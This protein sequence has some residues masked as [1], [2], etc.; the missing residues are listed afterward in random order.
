MNEMVRQ[1]WGNTAG[2]TAYSQYFDAV[3][4]MHLNNYLL[5]LENTPNWPNSSQIEGSYRNSVEFYGLPASTAFDG[6]FTQSVG[7]ITS[8]DYDWPH[9]L[10]MDEARI[11]PSDVFDDIGF[12]EASQTLAETVYDTIVEFVEQGWGMLEDIV[13]FATDAVLDFLDEAKKTALEKLKD[14]V[15][16]VKDT[17]EDVYDAIKDL[18][19][20][21]K[22][23]I[24]R[25]DPLVLDLDGDGIETV[26]AT[27][28][29]LFDHDGDGVRSGTGWIS[30]DDGIL[31]LDRN[32]NGLIDS[33]RELFGADTVLSDGSTAT[34]GFAALADLDANDDGVFDAQDGQYNNVRV[35]RD[36]NQ[37]G[38]SQ[39]NE[40]FTLN[41]LGVASIQLTPSTTVDLDLGNGNVVDN[42]GTYTRLDGTVGLAGD[43]LLAM[44]H[45]FRDFT[46]SLDPVE[47]EAEARLLPRLRGS[48]AVR[49]LVEAAS[50]SSNLLSTL[51]GFAPGTTRDEMRGELDLVISLWAATSTM[52][53]SE[54]VLESSG[55]VPRTVLF[56]GDVPASVVAQGQA[57]VEAWKQQQHAHLAPII[58]I[59][60]RFN[61][62]SLITYQ[63][64]RV[65][66]GGNTYT[67]TTVALPGG[68]TEQVMSI[69]LRDEQIAALTSSYAELLESVYARLVLGTRLSAYIESIDTE[70]VGD[71]LHIGLASFHALLE[72][73][74]Q[75]NLAEALKD[76]VDLYRYGGSILARADWDGQGLLR[77]WIT[78]ASATQ[79]GLAALAAAGITLAQFGQSGTTG[80][81]V[82]WGSEDG[83]NLWGGAGG[84]LLVGNDGGD[85]LYGQDGRDILSGGAGYDWLN[86]G[87][88]DDQLTGGTENDSL[89]GGE[90]SD[91]Y[92]YYLGDDSDTINN[93][94]RSAGRFDVLVLG[95]GIT[96]SGVTVRRLG[97]SLIINVTGNSDQITVS[98][99]FAADGTG[100]YQ[101]DQIRFADGTVW[102]V[103]TLKPMVVIPTL[104]DDNLY[105]YAT[106]DALM[107]LAGN[108]NLFGYGGNDVL[109][110]GTGN[111]T[112]SGGEGSDTYIFNLGD[113]RDVIDGYDGSAGSFDVLQLGVGIAPEDVQA[114]RRGNSL[115]LMLANG[116]DQVMVNNYFLRDGAG[117]FQV[118]EIR[119]A[120]GTLWDV[121]EVKLRVQ[122]A[123]QGSD[124]LHGYET[125]D[126][127]G[128][129][130]GDDILNG[131]GGNDV[132]EGGLGNDTLT[133]G[134]GSDVYH[135][136][137][138]DGQDVIDNHDI[139]AGRVDALQLGAGIVPADVTARRQGD[140]L[141]LTFAN[142]TDRIT[143]MNYFAGDAAAGYQLDEIRFANGVVWNVATVMPLVQVPT[144]GAD[145]I[146]GYAGSDALVGLGGNDLIQGNAGDDTLEGG[147]GNDALAGGSGSDVYIFNAGD[148][149]D[150]I[151]NYDTGAGRTDSLRFGPGILPANMLVR[152][153]G[154]SLVL[155]FAGSEDQVTISNYF[156][157]DADGA[158]RLDEIR[159]DD[160]T[161]WDVAAVRQM[162]LAPTSGND[163]IQGYATND[164]IMGGE[165]NDTLHGYGGNDLLQGDEGDDTL[166]AGAGHDV[167]EGGGGADSLRGDGGDDVL[168]GGLGNDFLEGGAG[169]DTY[170]FNA[171]DG[172][173]TISNY[174]GDDSRVDVLA[175]GVGINPENVVARRVENN[176]VL[177]FL[178]SDD[179]VTVSNFFL[180]DAAGGYQLDQIRFLDANQTVWDVE[181]MK[182]LVL[183]P[184][185]GADTLRG[186]STNDSLS[187][188]DGDDSLF[189]HGG[190]DV[191]NG[192]AGNDVLWGGEDND[193]LFGGLGLD[194]LNGDDGDDVLHGGADN[195]TLRGGNGSDHLTGGT[196]NDQLEGGQ[197]DDH[198]YF[199]TGDGQDIIADAQG[200]STIHLS[201]IPRQQVYLRRDGTTL[202]LSFLGSST[203]G[204]R[205]VGFFDQATQLALRGLV[206]DTGDGVP[207][208]LDAEGIDAAAL[209][210]T[211]LD[212][213][214]EGNSLGNVI[215]GLSGNDTV[216]GGA[217]NDSMDGGAGN[218]LL[219]GQ[220]GNDTLAGAEG[221]DVLNGGAGADHL[222]GGSGNDV[223]V[224]DNAGDVVV[225]SV[226][227]GVDTI[228]SSVSF[229]LIDNVEHLTLIGDADIS[230]NGNTLDNTL[231]G[232]GGNNNLR[233]HSGN[234]VL[235]GREGN[236]TLHGDAGEDHLDGGAG[237]D[238]LVGGT[239]NDVYR[240]D[241]I[242]D[243]IVEYASEGADSVESTAYSYTLSA[244]IESLTLVEASGAY[245]GIGN[246]EVNVL[247]G[248][249]NDNRL[250]GGAGADTMI[251]GYGNDIYVI[252]STGDVIIENADGGTDTV[253]SSISYT[254]GATLENLTLLGS[255]DLNATGNDGDN[256]IQGNEGSNRIE[257]GE[258]ADILS[259]GAGDDYY[260]A[261][262]SDDSVHE[263]AGEG[264]D[265][266]KR[267]FE[268]NLVLESNVENLILGSGIT[269]GNGNGLDN[270]I[271][272]NA[273]GNTLGGW[274]GDDLL[275]GLDGDD[276]LFGGDGT[277]TLLGGIGNDYLDGGAGVDL[278]EGGAGNDIYI[279]D[280]SADV[281][282][283]AAGAGTDQV[284]TTASYALSAN[285]ENLF[286]MEA[287]ALD[288]TGNALDN[289]I[290][291]NS[292]TN[293]IDGGGGS[294][295]LVAGAGDDTLIGGT[296]DDK[297]VFDETS[298]SDVI[299][300]SDGGFDGV[301]F[302]GGVTRERL[303]FSRDGDDLLIFIDAASTPSVRVLNHFLGGNAAIDYVQPDGGF[304]LT[305]TEINQIVAGGGTGGEYDQVIEGAAS[306]E[307]LVGGT[308]KDL[309]KGLAGNDQ[310]FGMGGNDTLQGGDG[311][312]YLAGGNGS[313]SGSGN[314]RLEGG[315]GADTLAGQDGANVLIGGAGNDSYVYGGGQDTIDN[316]GGG[317]DGVFFNNGILADDL[318]FSRE[319]DDLL[320]TIDG[321]ASATV[322]VTNHF[323]GGDY[324]ID[325]VQPASGSLLNTA[326]I[327]A[328]TEDDGGNPGGG[329]NEG[330]DD[331]YSNVVTGT[332][333]GE[334]LLGTSGRDLIR[335]L[336]GNDTLFGFGGDDKF[337]GGDG[338][339][340]ISGGNGSF[341]G[342]GNDILI[343][344][345]GNDTLV[346][347]D[348]ADM[349]IGGA[350]DDDYYYSAGSGSDTIDNIGGGTDWV[351]FNGI[352]RERLSFH[353]DGDDLLIRVDASA[354]SQVRV[355]GHFLGGNQAIS[356]V[357]PGSGYAIPASEIPG[358]LASLPQ[359]FAAVPSGN[360]S[361]LIA[362][363][364][365]TASAMLAPGHGRV[366][367]S[368][369]ARM[370]GQIGI[371]RV[372][373]IQE[374]PLVAADTG[375]K[376]AITGG[377]GQPTLVDPPATT[378]GG[379]VPLLERWEHRET[380][381]DRQFSGDVGWGEH[382][383]RDIPVVH[384][385][386]SPDIRQ[387]EG[388]I[389][390]MAGFGSDG[391]V[392]ML[393]MARAEHRD[394][395]MFAVQVL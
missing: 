255:A 248:N 61:G 46:G 86:G 216:R 212:D 168:H 240:V 245:E 253:E 19:D 67:W 234:D 195:D 161:V 75:D 58:A 363:E 10:G 314:D 288:G 182:E 56:H 246:A 113:G 15:D 162:A 220:D 180:A 213:V 377:T 103:E 281:V 237:M 29:V 211:D 59:L 1:H 307:Q 382:W 129:L 298:G 316:A 370:D 274:D 293:V 209:L 73:K 268:T 105:G 378:G 323:L 178:G 175:L 325:F 243:V 166:F 290:A 194:T 383:R 45:Y 207:W 39:A 154:D 231:T 188:G 201:G 252:D 273:E 225:E 368:L 340:Y 279:V 150:V 8:G 251:G 17:V 342:S 386:P 206:L 35:W 81:D 28:A 319:G 147:L 174:D 97:D 132:L 63:N 84:D 27:G 196:G 228:Q 49:D 376:P 142:G 291:G 328:L 387:L 172:Q 394:S 43:L 357:Q 98:N 48:G 74:R 133:G 341:S 238:Q 83:N 54:Q 277:D 311:D 90:G 239:G 26:S 157:N 361:A 51:Q 317:Y 91:T 30:S 31:V 329:G 320:I 278:L 200:T 190:D 191:L 308:G 121:E 169:S 258:G 313:G 393:P 374:V 9:A 69:E 114:F 299:D 171:G 93:F 262:S 287:G 130:T 321:N 5:L 352:A 37:D 371:Q 265:T 244:N 332:A 331:D 333:S 295:T 101:L 117:G 44:D 179:K 264:D 13:E 53:S 318:A 109:Q 355:L 50:L 20:E 116:T 140:S 267:V 392:D 64:D 192:D 79:S 22:N 197:G 249:S 272:G 226:S 85:T 254:L 111:D 65:S 136:S 11:V 257:S 335:G 198:Y 135:F 33:G 263:Y 60:E 294:D 232:N 155:T 388:L 40:L 391:G 170:I 227:G 78:E 108:D 38:V 224:V 3:A 204:I 76:L 42:R 367:Q 343:G 373:V 327:N 62:S 354:A 358:L 210:G 107:G 134:A 203:D 119:F 286:L 364:S 223:Y 379:L 389:S 77:T 334:Q 214:I 218:D 300:N 120:D 18:F 266:V 360:S 189:G 181:T 55:S 346:G 222:I 359:G 152:R 123:T 131:H 104:G 159:F 82:L 289:Y 88:G 322:R 95:E 177:T 89:T 112:L 302:T 241:E 304:Y 366:T 163:V 185:T 233:G 4:L 276:A 306:G 138:G 259:G 283:E 36:L 80:N 269:T 395:S 96:P 381:W 193:T 256:V 186:Y 303:S 230:A 309:V 34:S 261:V 285:I 208:V 47:V 349:L 385:D 369:P 127:L 187:G 296:G 12:I 260:V 106:A 148:G 326:A 362:Q 137:A 372:A 144:A 275:H 70:F 356:Y 202:V 141:V 146:H 339:D 158:W 219:Y 57:A 176:L 24:P 215:A 305:T 353:Q 14:F 124:E 236:D 338:D 330:N 126:T 301:F 247:T 184:T 125:N 100:G 282:I 99:Y 270:T 351:F 250:D 324:A 235:L 350:G 72:S 344:G 118:D 183:L 71:D 2:S 25:R 292:D 7:T 66:T 122:V 365:N 23:F 151:N 32:G 52:Q 199:S 87:A 94:D 217:G 375:R 153:A 221:D 92:F 310:L 315:A 165:G 280:D 173:D 348:G 242:G 271:T 139:S 160:G 297:Y 102:T 380:L 149:Q 156:Y 337:E 164:T 16:S 336:A 143:V 312:D 128:G 145:E 41:Q 21:A 284:Q 390:A 68:A 384:G 115:V 167:L 6:V 205:L 347:E 229:T 110:G 345:N